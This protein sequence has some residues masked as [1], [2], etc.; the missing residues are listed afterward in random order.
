MIQM[1]VNGWWA[2]IVSRLE[3]IRRLQTY[4]PDH[5][6]QDPTLPLNRGGRSQSGRAI[7]NL[8]EN[9]LR[10]TPEGGQRHP[11]DGLWMN[12]WVR[13]QQSQDTGM[14]IGPA[15]MPHIFERFYRADSARQL[16]QSGTGIGL[17]IVKK[18]ADP[19]RR[20][21]SWWSSLPGI[22]QHPPA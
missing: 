5:T 9:A 15:N 14:G 21:R 2:G 10:Y 6:E 18:V 11:A 22:R 17:A 1:N 20:A 13:N 8:A 3:R 7:S 16:V 19:H 4:Q 12:G